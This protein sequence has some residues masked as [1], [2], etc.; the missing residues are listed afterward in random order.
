MQP[1]WLAAALITALVYLAAPAVPHARGQDPRNLADSQSPVGRW[2]V[3]ADMSER[4]EYAGGV[5]LKD[6]RVLAVSGHPLKGKSIASAELYDS[7]SGKWSDTGQLNQARNGGNAATLLPDGRVLLAGGHSN[8]NVISGAELYDPVNGQWSGTGS[9]EVG[10]EGV[11]TLLADGRVLLTGGIDWYID[12]GKIFALAE[13]YDPKNGQWAPTGSLGTARND[14][15]AMLLDNGRVLVIGGHGASGALVT[16]AELY[17]P[18]TGQWQETAAPVEPRGWCGLVKLSDG[19]V[20]LVGGYHG[21]SSKPTYLTSAMLYDAK[22][23]KWSE[24]LPMRTKRAGF[25]TTLLADGRVLVAGGV[26]ERG[27][28]LMTA[29]IFDPRTETWRPAATMNFARRNH[30]AALLPDGSVL[31]IGG[32][33]TFGQKYLTSCEIFGF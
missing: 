9:L 5:R 24:T 8:K 23:Q 12:S 10:R 30:R 20:L 16:T 3:V 11:S 27:L 26:G 15:R 19:R 13:V 29:E 1:G 25:S 6:G 2:R 32:S 14:H 18:S 33:N 7:Q 21:S 31:V 4:R 17:D 22:T 28:E